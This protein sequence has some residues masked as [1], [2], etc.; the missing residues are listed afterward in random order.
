MNKKFK[1]VRKKKSDNASHS[2]VRLFLFFI[3]TLKPPAL[4][5]NIGVSRVLLN[6][7]TA[8]LDVVAHKH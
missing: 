3:T 6:E 5:V 1:R 7:H 2:A 8:R 4:C